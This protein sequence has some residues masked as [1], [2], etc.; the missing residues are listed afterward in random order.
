M[1]ATQ[2]R[3]DVYRFIRQFFEEQ[4]MA[5]SYRQICDGV[6]IASTSTV[7]KDLHILETHGLIK[8]TEGNYRSMQLVDAI[9]QPSAPATATRDDIYDIPVYGAVAAGSPIYA[10]DI[11]ETTLPLPASFFPNDGG[12][13]FLLEI[14][15]ES[16]IDAGIFDGDHVIVRRQETARNGQQ[17][18]AL[19]ED[20]ATVKTFYRHPDHIELRP[21]NPNY[22]PIRV[23]DCRILGV[24][25]GLYRIY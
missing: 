11:C 13:Y 3:R 15:G 8:M 10:D 2:R 14:H 20:E 22:R 23:R 6:G 12:D 5:P 7:S 16:M 21:E 24:V 18:V 25:C 19:I 9:Q 17:V 4:G 1:D